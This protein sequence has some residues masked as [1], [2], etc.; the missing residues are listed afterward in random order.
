MTNPDSGEP[1]VEYTYWNQQNNK[2]DTGTAERVVYTLILIYVLYLGKLVAKNIKDLLIIRR[3]I[4]IAKRMRVN[5]FIAIFLLGITHF[6][7]NFEANAAL[8]GDGLV[9]LFTVDGYLNLR[10][11]Y[12]LQYT[13]LALMEICFLGAAYNW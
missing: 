6:I 13:C 4:N 3:S 5:I 11:Y 7:H 12:I 1:C 9:G 8:Y 10:W 2:D